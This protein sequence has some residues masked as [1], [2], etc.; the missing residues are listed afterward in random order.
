MGAEGKK[1]DYTVIGG[2]VSEKDRHSHFGMMGL[3]YSF[4]LGEKMKKGCFDTAALFLSTRT[5]L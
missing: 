3:R 1:T 5:L 2:H 4:R